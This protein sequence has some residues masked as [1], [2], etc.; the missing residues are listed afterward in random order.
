LSYYEAENSGKSGD[1]KGKGCEVGLNGEN[2]DR[3]RKRG[4][5]VAK[6]EEKLL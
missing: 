6:R 1:G 4:K 3:L 2:P 5:I